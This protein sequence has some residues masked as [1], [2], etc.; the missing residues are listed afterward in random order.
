MK[1][2]K[3]LSKR[4]GDNANK[5]DKR[6]LRQIGNI[7]KRFNSNIYGND[8]SELDLDNLTEEQQK[9]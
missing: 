8:S 6:K 3:V 9:Y 5:T 2:S 1:T 4:E 7:I